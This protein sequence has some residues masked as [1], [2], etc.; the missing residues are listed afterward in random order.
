[1]F[2]RVGSGTNESSMSRFS[3]RIKSLHI[4]GNW[5]SLM[6]LRQASV[7]EKVHVFGT[8]LITHDWVS[9]SNKKKVRWIQQ[10]FVTLARLADRGMPGHGPLGTRNQTESE[11][12]KTETEIGTPARV[13]AETWKFAR[14]RGSSRALGTRG[15]YVLWN[16]SRFHLTLPLREASPRTR[17]ARSLKIE[18]LIREIVWWKI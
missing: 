13:E 9:T 7:V 3:T 8:C 17:A 2:L 12:W 6:T 5:S 18:T 4:L 1:M 15:L 11:C 10:Q 14:Q 16:Y